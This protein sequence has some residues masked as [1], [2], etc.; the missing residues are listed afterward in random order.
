MTK[1]LTA[2][3]ATPEL[4]A[5]VDLGS[6]SFHLLVGRVEQTAQ[7]PRVVPI[8]SLKEAVRLAS[9]LSADKRLEDRKSVV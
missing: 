1:Q 9:G 8:D 6:N 7:G 3:A 5:A 4:V 2:D